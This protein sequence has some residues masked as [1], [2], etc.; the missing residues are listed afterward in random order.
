MIWIT[1]SAQLQSICGKNP[2][3]IV[4]TGYIF[5]TK[6]YVLGMY[7]Y[8]SVCTCYVLLC[9]RTFFVWTAYMDWLIASSMV[10]ASGL[11][12]TSSSSGQGS[13]LSMSGSAGGCLK[14]CKAWLRSKSRYVQVHTKYILVLSWYVI[15]EPGGSKFV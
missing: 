13:P 14:S 3:I 5:G 2:S 9:T 10:A 7:Q 12:K 8:I 4:C 6:W 15:S 1:F 11:S